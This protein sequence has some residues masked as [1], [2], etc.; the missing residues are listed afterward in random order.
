MATLVKK[1]RNILS[2]LAISPKKA[3][4]LAFLAVFVIGGTIIWT[5][6]AEEQRQRRMLAEEIASH[7]AQ[8]IGHHVNH[9]IASLH[10]LGTLTRSI[11]L[12]EHRFQAIAAQLGSLYPGIAEMRLIP[13]TRSRSPDGLLVYRRPGVMH[14]FPAPDGLPENPFPGNGSPSLES[15][16]VVGD[17]GLVIVVGR[18]PV[19]GRDGGR[20]G[21]DAATGL[22]VAVLLMPD[23]ADTAGLPYLEKLGYSYEFLHLSSDGSRHPVASSRKKPEWP[24]AHR[25]GISGHSWE[26][27]ISPGR[28]WISWGTVWTDVALL[29]AI[30]L[31]FAML[32]NMIARLALAQ[33]TLRTSEQ[34]FRDL[35]ELSSDWWWEQDEN[36]RYTALSPAKSY[37]GLDAESHLGKMLWQLDNTHLPRNAS[38]TPHI[39]TLVA[40]R[41]FNLIIERRLP[42][43]TRRIKVSGKP[44]FGP[45]GRFTG[46]RGAATDITEEYA[47][48]QS[49]K[50]SEAN[51]RGI[52]NVVPDPLIVRDSSDVIRQVNPGACRFFGASAPSDLIGRN[53]FDL[54]PPDEREIAM[55]RSKLLV[56]PQVPT[57]PARRRFL[58][59]DGKTTTGEITGLLLTKREGRMILSVIHDSSER[60]A[61]TQRY[62]KLQRE[63]VRQVI[64]T[65]E[66]ERRALSI[67]LHDRIGQTLT[68]VRF[69]LE[70]LR[71]QLPADA[72]AIVDDGLINLHGLLQTVTTDVRDLMAELHPPALDDHGLRTALAFHLD[73]ISQNSGIFTELHGLDFKPRLPQ[74]IEL[75]LFRIAQEA[76]HNILK[77]ARCTKMLVSLHSDEKSLGMTVADNGVG[78]DPALVTG[79]KF[80]LRIMRERAESIGAKLDIHQE[81]GIGTQITVTLNRKN[82][83][84]G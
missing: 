79:D 37:A 62:E 4:T 10:H 57:P 75:T 56:R 31:V 2:G 71:E 24:L 33:N 17:D 76:L 60:D 59:L 18:L 82:L 30:S 73:K 32:A 45:D 35:A 48:Q 20:S 69:N 9:A 81:S 7:Y 78:F 51:F 27:G 43:Q 16:V 15:D 21:K 70:L 47:A 63:L 34:R 14:R 25:F 11:P 64:A 41:P 12:D 22:A 61:A 44:L 46:Y 65:R 6:R 8:N 36:L 23:I 74:N 53:W 19:S 84:G 5:G 13:E 50:E 67:E 29:T 66:E 58:R 52:F 40:R 72:R 68:A 42:G 26:L 83:R 77:H 38:W 28:G 54:F 55:K 49:L 80:G 3:A 39:E 1:L